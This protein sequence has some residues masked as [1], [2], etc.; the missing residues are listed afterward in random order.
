MAAPTGQLI[1]AV[2]EQMSLRLA[3]LPPDRAHRAPFLNVYRR[4]TLAVQDEVA[5]AGFEDPE[6]VERWDV[7]FADLYFAAHDADLAGG[8]VS[9]PWRLAFDASAGQPPLRQVLLGM[10]A[11]V[12]YDLPQALLA[13]VG[14]QEF[15]QPTVLA[16]RRR[17]HERIDAVLGQR[18]GAEDRRLRDT[19]VRT[20]VLD[21]LLAPLNRRASRRFLAESRRKVW[22]NTEQLNQARLAGRYEQRLAELE[23]LAAGKVADLLEPGQVL[24][25]LAAGGFGVVLP[26]E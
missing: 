12:N 5:N 26:P 25:K 9:R 21:R 7:V 13:V 2:A 23:I 4:T 3:E 11:H 1:G 20:T 10:N 15:E 16:R 19:D 6:W 14:P 24:L 22:H 17:D 8:P 18:V